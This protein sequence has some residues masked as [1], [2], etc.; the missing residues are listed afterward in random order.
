MATTEHKLIATPGGPEVTA[1][2]VEPDDA[3]ALLMLGPGAGT[4]IH[5]PLMVQLADALAQHGVASFRYNYPYGE[6]GQVYAVEHI[7]PLDVLLTTTTSAKAAAQALLPDLPLFLGGRSMSA[8]LVSLVLT[9][10]EWPEVRGAVLYVFPNRWRHVMDDTISHLRQVP[11]PMLFV[12]G[13][14]DEEEA[15]LAELKSVLDGLGGRATLHVIEGANHSYEMPEGSEWTQTDAIEDAA[16]ATAI[17]IEAQ[18]NSRDNRER[19]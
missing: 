16:A 15:P 18:L 5:R 17:W 6:R 3:F 4:P 7:D 13:S 8:Q 12:Q 19:P 1:V 11:T 14:R 9:H 10:E 2:L